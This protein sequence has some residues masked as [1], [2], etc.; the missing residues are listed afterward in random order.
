MDWPAGRKWHM[1]LSESARPVWRKWDRP[2]DDT[3]RFVRDASRQSS[4]RLDMVYPSYKGQEIRK[5]HTSCLEISFNI[6]TSSCNMSCPSYH[7]SGIFRTPK[8]PC[9]HP[10]PIT[11]FLVSDQIP[12]AIWQA[13]RWLHCAMDNRGIAVRPPAVARDSS[14][15]CNVQTVSE[16]YP[17]S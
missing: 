12:R 6:I 14:V 15:L 7:H 8:V 16:F 3:H 13:V 10:V 1:I 9:S 4:L 11:A 2:S 17:N 5:T